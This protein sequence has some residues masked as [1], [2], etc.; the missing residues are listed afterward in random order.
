MFGNTVKQNARQ[1]KK[2]TYYEE[3]TSVNI[4]M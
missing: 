1:K 4:L 3:I 2:K